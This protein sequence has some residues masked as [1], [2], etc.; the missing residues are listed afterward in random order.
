MAGAGHKHARG[1][2]DRWQCN[3]SGTDVGSQGTRGNKAGRLEEGNE[4]NENEHPPPSFF[5]RA[6]R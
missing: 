1:I 5:Y 2:G 4:K 3:G 6:V